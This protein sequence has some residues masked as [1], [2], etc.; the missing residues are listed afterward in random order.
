MGQKQPYAWKSGWKRLRQVAADRMDIW[1][2]ETES[3]AWKLW[4]RT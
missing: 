1:I 4:E 3:K 2:L